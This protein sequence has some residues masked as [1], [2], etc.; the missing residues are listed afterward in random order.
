MKWEL[1]ITNS[2]HNHAA[3]ESQTHLVHW[4]N[5]LNIKLLND[6]QQSCDADI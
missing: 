6:L 4:Q 3:E 2:D 1:I 5:E